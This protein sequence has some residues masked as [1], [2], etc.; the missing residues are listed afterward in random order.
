[1]VLLPKSFYAR[2]A[3]EV[4]PA[5][6]GQELRH[7]EVR[8]RITEVEA[9]TED[10]TACHAYKGRT[11]RTEVLFGPPGR[12]YVYLC[13]GIHQMLNLVTDE[14]QAAAV[15]VRACEP[16]AGLDLIRERRGGKEGPVLLTGPGKVG[17]ALGVD[18]SFSGH[19]LYRRGGVE[20]HRG[21]TPA[22]ILHGPRV[23]IDYADA[24]DRDAPWR[25]AIAE[26]PWVSHRKGLQAASSST[27]RSTRRRQRSS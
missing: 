21:E 5:L 25:F 12:A 11:A 20:L 27:S 26:T 15:L 23:G 6:L 8:L 19:M 18:T 10:D 3:L 1:M 2:H 17:Q 9:Y 14:G 4:A 24:A 16:V 7:G 22:A 13:Y